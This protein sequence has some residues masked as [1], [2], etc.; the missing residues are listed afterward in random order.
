M[1]NFS[2]RQPQTAQLEQVL[3]IQPPPRSLIT[4]FSSFQTALDIF[5]S[6]SNL[7]ARGAKM[8]SI[9][10]L[11]TIA[12]HFSRITNILLFCFCPH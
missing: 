3:A 7:I 2:R 1:S 12:F 11:P 6:P 9:H 5:V 4:H 10:S 8:N